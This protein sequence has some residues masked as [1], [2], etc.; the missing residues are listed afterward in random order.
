MSVL[1]PLAIIN[2]SSITSLVRMAL[3]HR[4]T[5]ILTAEVK[6]KADVT[7]LHEEARS[8]GVANPVTPPVNDIPGVGTVKDQTV[9]E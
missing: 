8:A 3:Y 9:I 2:T 1:Y 5:S 7:G 4:S 6:T